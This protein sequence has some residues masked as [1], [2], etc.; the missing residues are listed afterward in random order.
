MRR[1]GIH[2]HSICILYPRGFQHGMLHWYSKNL[3]YFSE[4]Y[5][6]FFENWPDHFWFHFLCLQK[7]KIR[8]KEKF[9][10]G[11]KSHPKHVVAAIFLF[12]SMNSL[13]LEKP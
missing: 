11:T 2:V 9:G 10:I 12:T 1:L 13:N 6:V 3:L 4:I 5:K 7:Q 8:M